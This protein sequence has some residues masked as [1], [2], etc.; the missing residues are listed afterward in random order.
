MEQFTIRGIAK[1]TDRCGILIFVSLAERY[2]RIIADEGIDVKVPQE[3]WQAAVDALIDHARKDDIADGFIAA[4]G[5]C[6]TELT[7]HF[8]RT[9]PMSEE[10]PDRVYVI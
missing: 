2:A 3:A 4:I 8:P 10:L 6:G 5:L 7:K 1:K 9:A